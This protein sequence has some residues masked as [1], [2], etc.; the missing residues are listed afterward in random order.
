MNLCIDLH[1]SLSIDDKIHQKPPNYI[2]KYIGIDKHLIDSDRHM[3]D[4]DRRI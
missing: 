4:Q 3:I 1:H 2:Y